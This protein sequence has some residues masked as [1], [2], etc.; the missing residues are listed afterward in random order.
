M[1]GITFSR[2]RRAGRGVADEAASRLAKA[3]R[4]LGYAVEVLPAA[5]AT[6]A[7]APDTALLLT[8]EREQVLVHAYARRHGALAQGAVQQLAAERFEVGAQ[9]AF[10]I[11]E[12]GFTVA[13]HQAALRHGDLVMADHPAAA[14]QPLPVVDVYA[15][16][17]ALRAM[18]LREATRPA[19]PL[20][21]AISAGALAM[22]G[23]FVF[24]SSPA[25]QSRAER[26]LRQ[27]APT[28]ALLQPAGQPWTA[29]A[30][31]RSGALNL[32]GSAEQAATPMSADAFGSLPANFNQASAPRL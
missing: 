24:V 18:S 27:P 16:R 3:Y 30:Q 1:Q 21:A 9:R 23:I 13:A 12:G 26:L 11:G 6:S 8:K 14:D 7:N 19:W 29:P 28:M 22:A 17:A 10:L 20:R 5:S 25:L 31:S 15:E 2:D 4:A 32:G